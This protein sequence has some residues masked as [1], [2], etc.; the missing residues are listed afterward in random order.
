MEKP[1]GSL[2]ERAN[3]P[4]LHLRALPVKPGQKTAVW[5]DWCRASSRSCPP[6]LALGARL[7]VRPGGP[8]DSMTAQARGEEQLRPLLNEAAL[9]PLVFHE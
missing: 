8:R 9:E 5:C 4:N 2:G 6:E 3:T 7:S 1:T